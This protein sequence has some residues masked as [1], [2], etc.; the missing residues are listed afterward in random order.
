MPLLEGVG[1]VL[2]KNQPEHDVLVLGRI[3][4]VAEL[5]SRQPKLGLEA[6]IGGGVRSRFR[7]AYGHWCQSKK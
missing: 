1:D 6:E 3:H 5:V 4:V 7:L 2:Q